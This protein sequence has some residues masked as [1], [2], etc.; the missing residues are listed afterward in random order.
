MANDV[1][2]AL[3]DLD[4]AITLLGSGDHSGSD[5]AVR[6]ARAH[7]DEVPA[8]VAFIDDYLDPGAGDFEWNYGHQRAGYEWQSGQPTIDRAH[9][10]TVLRGRVALNDDPSPVFGAT[11]S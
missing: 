1:T 4:T 2:S 6:D 11:G 3:A 7:I 10:L 9:A 8:L 5:D